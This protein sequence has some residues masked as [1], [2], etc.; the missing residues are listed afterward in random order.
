[1]RS[2]KNCSMIVISD[3]PSNLGESRQ[4]YPVD[5]D[6]LLKQGLKNANK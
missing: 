6:G 1:M 2:M 4:K 5:G 3:G